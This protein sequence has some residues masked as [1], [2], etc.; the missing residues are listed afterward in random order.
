[1]NEF[2]GA[3]SDDLDS[4]DLFPRW[5]CHH[6]QDS[7]RNARNLATCNFIELGMAYKRISEP[8]T[9][10]RLVQPH[11]GDFR[12]RV[13]TDR[14]ITRQFGD[15]KFQRMG[16]GATSLFHRTG[17]QHGSAGHVAYRIDVWNVGLTILVDD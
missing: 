3:L 2:D 10:R 11:R 14:Y 4:E 17:C 13:D 9:S 6:F 7:I 12:Q 1:M 8:V 15:R 5:V 16:H